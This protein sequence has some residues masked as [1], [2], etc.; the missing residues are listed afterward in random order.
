MTFELRVNYRAPS[1]ESLF[2]G[3][4]WELARDAHGAYISEPAAEILIGN[5]ALSRECPSTLKLI[6]SMSRRSNV[7]GMLVRV[8]GSFGLAQIFVQKSK[9]SSILAFPIFQ[10]LVGNASAILLQP[11]FGP[12][13]TIEATVG[14]MDLIA[15]DELQLTRN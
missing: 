14:S 3:T 4:G 6:L 9:Q 10:D 5:W 12:N 13:K 2:L 8:S 7:E 1:K 11:T 15:L